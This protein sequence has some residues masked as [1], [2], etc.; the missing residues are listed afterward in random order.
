MIFDCA[1]VFC[2]SL[3]RPRSQLVK[4]DVKVEVKVKEEKKEEIKTE[5]GGKARR[6]L[7]MEK[8]EEMFETP[9]SSS[10]ALVRLLLKMEKKE[11]VVESGASASS[12][13]ARVKEEEVAQASERMTRFRQECG[14]GVVDLDVDTESIPAEPVS[15][16]EQ[17][18]AEPVE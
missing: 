6:L 18:F 10:A 7:K 1:I 9:A 4:A 12:G 17:F 2:V 11:E 8:K 13:V 15:D 5:H 14:F 3:L 16:D